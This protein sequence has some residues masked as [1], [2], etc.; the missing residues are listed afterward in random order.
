MIYFTFKETIRF[1][2]ACLLHGVI[3]AILA[4]ILFTVIISVMFIV[5]GIIHLNEYSSL[6]GLKFLIKS[7]PVSS[8][9]NNTLLFNLVDFL[10]IMIYG[11]TFLT[12]IYSYYDGVFRIYGLLLSLIPYYF[13]ST[14]L[15]EQM[16]AILS[17]PLKLIAKYL[18]MLLSVIYIPIKK[19]YGLISWTYSHCVAF[20]IKRIRH[21][22][23]RKRGI[24]STKIESGVKVFKIK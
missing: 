14:G 7:K 10:N 6:K 11:T 3:C 2:F 22:L 23:K 20:Y 16:V 15:K 18:L 12:V 19:T 24:N 5:Q 9:E 17:K 13:I 8:Y 1:S 4:M 21:L